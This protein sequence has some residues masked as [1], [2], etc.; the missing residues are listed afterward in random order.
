MG[1]DGPILT[2]L[3]WVPGVQP[4]GDPSAPRRRGGV[5]LGLRRLAP[6]VHARAGDAHPGAAGRRRHHGVRPVCAGHVA[7]RGARGRRGA[8]HALGGGLQGGAAAPRPAPRGDRAGR[9]GRGAPRRRSAAEV[10]GVGFDAYAHRRPQRGRARRRDARHGRAHGRPAA[11]GP[12][13]LL[14]GHRRP[15][16][17]RRRDRARRRRVRLRAADAHGAH[18]HGAAARRQAAEPAQRPLRR[19]PRPRSRRAATA[20][21]AAPSPVRTCATWSPRRRCSAPSS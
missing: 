14:H 21:R 7:A 3:G 5:Q 6:R 16:G 17:P 19:R 13:A 20:T 15:R 10:M 11:D 9:Y 12:P 4:G 1:W 2:G 18:G 8:H